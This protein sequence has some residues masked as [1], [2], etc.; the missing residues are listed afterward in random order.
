MAAEDVLKRCRRNHS[1]VGFH[2]VVETVEILLKEK[3]NRIEVF[4]S[5]GRYGYNLLELRETEDGELAAW[6]LAHYSKAEYTS[7]DG[8]LTA[9]LQ[10]LGYRC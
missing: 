2:R 4:E 6:H 5:A 10:S 8:A 7:S 1:A 9:A 3:T